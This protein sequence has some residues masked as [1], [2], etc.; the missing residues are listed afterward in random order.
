MNTA[1]RTNAPGE[2]GAVAGRAVGVQRGTG[3]P[4]LSLKIQEGHWNRQ[5]PERVSRES[6][7]I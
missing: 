7:R 2:I 5:E 4:G 3:E 1:E 6:L